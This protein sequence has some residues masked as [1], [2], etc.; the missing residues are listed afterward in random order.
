MSAT[1]LSL[2]PEILE[3][4]LSQVDRPSLLSIA[5]SCRGLTPG[6][7]QALASR[8]RVRDARDII[9]VLRF[10]LRHPDLWLAVREFSIEPWKNLQVE[11]CCVPLPSDV[12]DLLRD[13]YGLLTSRIVPEAK[14]AIVADISMSLASF[15]MIEYRGCHKSP[16]RDDYDNKWLGYYVE[17]SHNDGY[18]GEDGSRNEDGKDRNGDRGVNAAEEGDL[19]RGG[20]NAGE[21]AQEGEG[22]TGEEEGSTPHSENEDEHTRMVK[23]QEAAEHALALIFCFSS[24]LN[25]F[26]FYSVSFQWIYEMPVLNKHLQDLLSHGTTEPT[27]MPPIRNL[28]LPLQ[29]YINLCPALYH[30][31]TLRR[32]AGRPSLDELAKDDIRHTVDRLEEICVPSASWG[33]LWHNVL[34]RCSK[35]RVLHVTRSDAPDEKRDEQ[36]VDDDESLNSG[37]RAR[38]STL[39]ELTLEMGEGEDGQRT[40]I[41]FGE[42][43][44]HMWNYTLQCLPDMT[45][46]KHLKLDIGLLYHP[47]HYGTARR[48]LPAVRWVDMLPPALETLDMAERWGDEVTEGIV[49]YGV[50]HGYSNAILDNIYSLLPYGMPSLKRFTFRMSD[51]P[52]LLS[53][54]LVMDLQRLASHHESDELGARFIVCRGA[55]YSDDVLSRLSFDLSSEG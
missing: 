34:D 16:S 5:K 52:A 48:Q 54:K 6:A 8:L 28:E 31:S 41:D 25:S 21:G 9:A 15:N 10:L 37:L 53:E 44:H 1:I 38:A 30:I 51:V 14:I 26:R 13:Q 35:L 23:A 32:V 47:T 45:N 27:L 12:V 29:F 33:R 39:E 4:I 20:R 42:A 43:D 49:E 36:W 2:P 17:E 19:E 50:K 24:Q 3:P 7:Q 18:G 40:H 22:Q 11:G 55:G 46:L